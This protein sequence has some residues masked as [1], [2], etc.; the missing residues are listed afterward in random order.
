MLQRSSASA[1]RLGL[2]A[3]AAAVLAACQA[4]GP[5]RPPPSP[6]LRLL[7]SQP[8]NLPDSCQHQGSVFVAFTVNRSGQTSDIQPDA[9]PACVQQA[10]TA[11]VASFRYSPPAEQ[12]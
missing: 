3:A 1:L 8:L 5:V 6:P 7:G 4:P 12:V 10:L 2:F 9:A 11:W